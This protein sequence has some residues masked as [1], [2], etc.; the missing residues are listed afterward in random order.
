[1][2]QRTAGREKMPGRGFEVGLAPKES[3]ATECEEGPGHRET[4]RT[5]ISGGSG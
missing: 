4:P 3:K 1:M 2:R 5:S